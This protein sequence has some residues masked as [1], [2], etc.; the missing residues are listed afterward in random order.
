MSADFQVAAESAPLYAAFSRAFVYPQGEG[1]L[2]GP[3]FLEAFDP[4][5]S[6]SATALNEVAYAE[7]E[8]SAL[9]EE[10]VR[11]YEH[12]GLRRLEA[13]ELPDHV[14]VELEF[15]HVL[16]EIERHAAAR[17]DETA[18]L[19]AAQRDFLD[20]HLRRL[21]AGMHARRSGEDDKATV[22]VRECLAFVESHRESLDA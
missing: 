22:I 19:R 10:L 8:A 1:W 11:F 6:S 20:R 5:V 7:I 12:F 14:G 2:S 21:L 4:A 9:F 13:A 15:M 18:P 3:E 17:G 16:C